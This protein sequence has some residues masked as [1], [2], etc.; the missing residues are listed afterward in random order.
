MIGLLWICL[1][2]FPLL[3]G[4]GI[5]ALFYGKNTAYDMTVSEGCVLG[6]MVCIGISETVHAAG[7]F[8]N[9]SLQKCVDIWG[10][11]LIAVAIFSAILFFWR[12]KGQFKERIALCKGYRSEKTPAPFVFLGFVLLQMVLIYCTRPLFTEGDI[13]LETVQSF[14]AEDGIYRVLPLTGKVS[15]A[16]MPMRYGILCLPTVYAMLSAI[17]GVSPELLICHMIPVVITGIAYMSY[18]F[19]SGVL[20]GKEE[21]RKRYLFLLTVSIIFFFTDTGVFSNGY[22][23][24]HSAFLGTSVRNLIILPYLFGVTLEK[25]WWKAVICVLAEACIAWTLWGMGICVTVFVGMFILTMAEQKCPCLAKFLQI[26][27]NREDLP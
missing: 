21:L 24:F 23:V 27:R 16:G 10:I 1:I 3:L 26:F 11:L 5:L 13:T 7:Y 20:F 6:L 25:Q 4:S 17:F 19:L 9:W 12:I 15:E 14:L 22:H 18:Y 8:L 2:L